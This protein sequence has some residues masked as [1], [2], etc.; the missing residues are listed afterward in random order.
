MNYTNGTMNAKLNEARI[1]ENESIIKEIESRITS[2]YVLPIP[3][4]RIIF[5]YAEMD[6]SQI[7]FMQDALYPDLVYWYHYIVGKIEDLDR[8]WFRWW[9]VSRD[10]LELLQW[11]AIMYQVNINNF[12]DRGC[13]IRIYEN[14]SINILKWILSNCNKTFIEFTMPNLEYE[15]LYCMLR[16][17][18]DTKIL[19]CFKEHYGGQMEFV[20]MG[21]TFDLPS[22]QYVLLSGRVD[23][24]EW[25]H[26]NFN[27][28]YE[29][30]FDSEFLDQINSYRWLHLGNREKI[31]Q[32]LNQNKLVIAQ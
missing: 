16:D 5:G 20:L 28:N 15:N 13:A 7:G 24:I 32:W 9:I 22:L 8:P 12:H 27:F 31:I 4:N 25:F 23:I 2:T 6:E 1:V 30:I 29:D 11:Y 26:Q 19:D 18:K 10:Y 21:T 14:G 3:L 17:A